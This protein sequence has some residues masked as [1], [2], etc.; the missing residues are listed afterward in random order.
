MAFSRMTG[1]GL[2]LGAVL[3]GVLGE[4]VGRYFFRS[5]GEAG[6]FG[7]GRVTGKPTRKQ[8]EESCFGLKD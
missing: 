3:P 7:L 4:Y 5:S 2:F 1:A 8:G 6:L